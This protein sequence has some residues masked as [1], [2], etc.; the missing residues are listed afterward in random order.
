[1]PAHQ[2]RVE[3][4]NYFLKTGRISIWNNL[5]RA[6]IWLRIHLSASRTL[7]LLGALS[8]PQTPAAMAV[9]NGQAA[10]HTKKREKNGELFSH[11]RTNIIIWASDKVD[12]ASQ[13]IYNPFTS[14]SPQ[15]PA[16]MAVR[17]RRMAPVHQWHMD[18]D[19]L[20]P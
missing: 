3:K 11:N 12:N 8:G 14:G 6:Q 18:L 5:F 1:M 16:P 13:D 4:V 15:S 9:H 19:T 17:H 20:G 10:L 2:V 7:W